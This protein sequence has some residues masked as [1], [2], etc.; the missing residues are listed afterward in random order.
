[1]KIGNFLDRSNIIAV[2]GVSANPNKWGW[3]I[4]KALK[5]SAFNVYPVNPKYRMIEKDVCYAKLQA[6]P[7]RPDLAITVVPPKITEQIVKQCKNLKIGKVWMQ[8]GSESEKAMSFCKRNNIMAVY[9][10]CFVVDGLKR[11]L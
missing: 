8:P 1:M 6:L 11:K 10:A 9:N 7:Q 2:I 3:K 5:S 4:Y